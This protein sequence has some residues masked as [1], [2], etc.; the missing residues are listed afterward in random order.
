MTY[1]FFPRGSIAIS[2]GPVLLKCRLHSVI[3]VA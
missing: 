1:W 2:I 3:A